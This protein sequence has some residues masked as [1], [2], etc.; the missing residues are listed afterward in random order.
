MFITKSKG[1]IISV[2]ERNK[3]W[4]YVIQKPTASLW[5]GYVSDL[6]YMNQEQAL[7]EGLEFVYTL[8]HPIFPID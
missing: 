3:K 2:I 7:K 8:D 1:F 5:N 6:L 4:A